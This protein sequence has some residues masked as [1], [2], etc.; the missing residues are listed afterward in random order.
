M[1]NARQNPNRAL[2]LADREPGDLMPL[3][4]S[5][6]PALVPIAGKPVL[7]HCIEDLWE[8]GVREALVVVP[9]GDRRI[10]AA[11]GTGQR[12]GIVLRYVEST[13]QRLPAEWLAAFGP[14][15]DEPLFVARGDV[16]RGRSARALAAHAAGD[17]ADIVHAANRSRPLGMSLV[18][19]RC[20]GV[21]RLEWN[22]FR[23]DRTA[24]AT[25]L[26][27]IHP[28]GFA[29]L[30]GLPSLFEASLAAIGGD[31]A[32]L[33]IEGRRA[34]GSTLHIGP[35][36]AIARSV[37]NSAVCRVGAG[38]ELHAG[39]ELTG[40][41]DVGDR[42][43]IDDGA[44]LIDSVVMAGSYVGRGV[45]LQN[46]VACGRWLYRADLQTCQRVDDALL[47]A[48]PSADAA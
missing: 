48:G 33:V 29:L 39:V 12:F 22:V 7:H 36:A 14:A 21:N 45:R 1:N 10:R 41:V 6:P 9:E 3:A 23:Q 38:A 8:A 4:E 40:R 35:R 25:N 20:G 24:D 37:V 2:I 17:M 32:G 18:R 13:A 44:Q 26:A 19:R 15:A 46:A 28:V 31:F 30:D 43:V 5:L 11:T 27:E 16:L 47:L 42:C 34:P